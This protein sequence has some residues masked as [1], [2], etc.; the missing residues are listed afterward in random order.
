M[1]KRDITTVVWH[2]KGHHIEM[3]YVEGDPD[4]F[5]G[6]ELVISEMAENEGLWSVPTSR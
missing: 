2:Q 6:V 4:Y 1:L 5:Q 3:N